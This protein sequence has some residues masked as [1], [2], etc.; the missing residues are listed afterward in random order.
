VR[1]V[2][3]VLGT[4]PEITKL[5]P[6]LPLLDA[7][8]THIVVHTGQHYSIEMDAVFFRELALR[9][10]DHLL[11]VGSA[12]HG[13]Q[14]ARM[15]SRLE[16]VLLAE[17]PDVVL[18]QGDTNSTLCGALG[19]AKL[20]I[21]VVHL[22]AG[23]RS[24]DRA[25]PE[26]V[27]RVVVDHVSALLL[28]A[29]DVARANLAREGLAEQTQ[30][31]GSTAIDAVVRARPI[32]E[33]STVL[34]RLGL[35]PGAFVV[36]T[37]HRAANTGPD[38]LPGL[39]RALG[40]V[41]ATERVVFP[42]HPRTA[43]AIR[44]QGLALDPRIAAIEPLGYLDTLRLVSAAKALL[45]DSGGLQEE[46]AVLGTPV[47][48]LRTK[49]EWVYLVEAGVQQLVGCGYDAVRENVARW[50]SPGG[51]ADLR[52]HRA[53]VVSGAAARAVETI[54]AYLDRRGA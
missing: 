46:A 39:L 27:N 14:T 51:L 33:A 9:T 1:T 4:R 34:D 52:R 24:F 47:L 2:L 44:E 8:C 28:A 43:A 22:E 41:A 3:T 48:V 10:P 7:A 12:S 15:L 36:L 20:G 30:V 31:I 5:S 29:D 25:M 6:V 19:A 45:T 32:A 42:V 13:E 23:A 50:L 38:V 18:V 54:L 11:H 17:R 53:P 35:E 21:P 37:L 49:T 40:E 16:P 26:E